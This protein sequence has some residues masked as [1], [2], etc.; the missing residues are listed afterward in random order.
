VCVCFGLPQT[1]NNAHP[2]EAHCQPCGQ[3]LPSTPEAENIPI[4]LGPRGFLSMNVLCVPLGFSHWGPCAGCLL[5][6]TPQPVHRPPPSVLLK[7]NLYCFRPCCSWRGRPQ[8]PEGAGVE[9]GQPQRHTSQTSH[10]PQNP[11]VLGAACA[12]ELPLAMALADM[13][14]GIVQHVFLVFRH[15]GP[16]S[17]RGAQACCWQ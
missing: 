6:R 3:P 16:G 7:N 15:K 13:P 11:S 8:A 14:L 12:A 5:S 17:H 1:A 4:S 10:A 2:D 9:L